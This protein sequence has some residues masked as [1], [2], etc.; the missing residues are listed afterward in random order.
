ILLGSGRWYVNMG[1]GEVGLYDR[2]VINYFTIDG[3]W[4]HML[5]ARLEL[6]VT[7]ATKVDTFGC[8]FI[9]PAGV[10]VSPVA[11]AAAAPQVHSA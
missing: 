7:S 3:A 6:R 11:P 2:D 8:F 9:H 1:V 5:A 4:Y 10:T